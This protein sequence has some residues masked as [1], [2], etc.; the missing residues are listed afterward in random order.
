MTRSSRFRSAAVLAS[1]A[2][3]LL[4]LDNCHDGL[5]YAPATGLTASAD[6]SASIAA[7]LGNNGA[8]FDKVD[9]VFAQIRA[10][11]DVR[12]EQTT[13]FSPSAGVA[14]IRLEVP[15]RQTSEGVTANV[16]LRW[17]GKALF[18]GSA[19]PTLSVGTRTPVELPLIPVA[20]LLTCGPDLQITS[21]GPAG[22]LVGAALFATGDTIQNAAITW[23]WSATS[24]DAATV[25]AAG[26]VTAVKDG[27]VQVAC[28][29]SGL[30]GTR[31]LH[32]LAAVA[33][34]ELAPALDTLPVGGSVTLTPTLRD[35]NGNVITSSRPITWQSSGAAATVD[36][37]GKVTGVSVGTVQ[38]TATSGGKTGTAQIVVASPPPSVTTNAATNIA[39]TSATV[40]G[41]VRP[42]GPT[43]TAW[44]EWST[45][46]SLASPQSTAPQSMSNV[47]TDVAFSESLTGLTLGTT[48]YYRAVA[49]NTFGGLVR[50]ATLSFTTVRPPTVTTN[51]P[52]ITTSTYSLS[53]TVNPN[54]SSTSAMFQYIVTPLEGPKF[55]VVTGSQSIGSGSAPVTVLTGLSA[56]PFTTYTVTAMASNAAGTTTGNTVT[57][58]TGGAPVLGQTGGFYEGGCPAVCVTMNSSVSADGSVTDAW[59]ELSTDSLF[60]SVFATTPRQ[61]FAAGSASVQFGATA[62]VPAGVPMFVRAAATNALG[63]VRSASS[64]VQVIIGI[65]RQ[66]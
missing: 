65:N 61:S 47:S 12:T 13:P 33:K 34:I 54:G 45:D 48:Y 41:T 66:P 36:A 27:D 16:E 14:T 30:T 46:A 3:S 22:R 55:I 19:T 44:F 29:S 31:A 18:R 43:V 4:V 64:S 59:F 23:T 32:V 37:S 21:Y 20:A 42:N 8:A 63:T 11:S 2:T 9:Q 40:N 17:T 7:S 49:A 25:T 52:V 50:G 53:A 10:G 56:T 26:D 38:I 39:G 35:A 57:F 6:L 24:G 15:L 5:L 51:S 60:K 58:T 62:S 28:A 1:L